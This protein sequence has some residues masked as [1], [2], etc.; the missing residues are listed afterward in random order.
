MSWFPEEKR[1]W[2]EKI[3]LKTLKLGPI[4]NHMA[5]I[6]DGNRR[7]AKKLNMRHIQGHMCGFEKLAQVWD[8][9]VNLYSLKYSTN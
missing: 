5:F 2:L 8:S 1:S 6:M 7:F 3:C 4:P 9:H